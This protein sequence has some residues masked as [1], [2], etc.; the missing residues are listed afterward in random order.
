[1]S[2]AGVV[3]RDNE[4]FEGTRRWHRD[5]YAAGV[6]FAR[7]PGPIALVLGA[8][9]SLSSNCPNTAV[10]DHALGELILRWPGRTV[11]EVLYRVNQAEIQAR[12]NPLFDDTSPYIGYLS[13]AALGRRRRVHVLN[14]NWDPMIERACRLLGIP[15]LSF[16]LKRPPSEDEISR[17]LPI[18]S[19]VLVAHVH[20]KLGEECRYDYLTTLKL[21]AIEKAFVRRYFS[22][23]PRV[24]VGVSLLGDSDLV[25]L[26]WNEEAPA[27]TWF[28]ARG[29][30][31][32]VVADLRQV[33]PHRAEIVNGE[34]IDFDDLMV[35][36][37][38]KAAH[39]IWDD[40]RRGREAIFL[41]PFSQIAWPRRT[42]LRP[43]LTARICPLV[44]GTRAGKSTLAHLLAYLKTL[45]FADV[46]SDDCVRTFKGARQ[47]VAALS[48]L[49]AD[50]S[51]VLILEDAFGAARFDDNPTL[52]EEVER[53]ARAAPRITMILTSRLDRWQEAEP[54]AGPLVAGRT[55]QPRDKWYARERLIQFAQV[56]APS[57]RSLV[58]AIQAGRLRT[59]AQ[60]ADATKGIERT[61]DA[62][63]EEKLHVL[64]RSEEL[65]LVATLVRLARFRSE[66]VTGEFVAGQ[67]G[68][69][70]EDMPFAGAFI[71]D[72]PFE[73]GRCL[74]L[75]HDEDVESVDRY[76]NMR[77]VASV[78]ADV[79]TLLDVD[80]TD[81]V[82]RWATVQAAERGDV[83]TVTGASATVIVDVAPD[84]LRT[85]WGNERV[86][87]LLIGAP[88]DHWSLLDLA[89]E[90][91]RLWSRVGRTAHG[92][93][94]L[95]RMLDDRTARG[96]Y[97]IL[98]ACL[99]LP[100]TASDEIWSRLNARLWQLLDNPAAAEEVALA[101][102]ALLWRPPPPRRALDEWLRA[103]EQRITGSDRRYG[104]WR[105]VVAYHPSGAR[106]MLDHGTLITDTTIGLDEEQREF[107]AWLVAWH[108]I[109]QSRARALLNRQP[110][111][112]K[113]FLCR[114]TYQSRQG[115]GADDVER[116]VRSLARRPS[117]APW[118]F[119]VV[120]NIMSNPSAA[121]ITGEIIDVAR[122][123]LAAAPVAHPGVV[124][125]A[126]TYESSRVFER[127]LQ[128]YFADEMSREALLEALASGLLIDGTVVA[129]PRFVYAL[130]PEL[131]Y[132]TCGV[133]WPAL[134]A[135][136]ADT[137]R[138]PLM[139]TLMNEVRRHVP[140][141]LAAGYTPAKVRA[142]RQRLKRGDL[143]NCERGA[144]QRQP[145]A[146]DGD[147]FF[148]LFEFVVR[149]E[150]TPSENDGT[151]F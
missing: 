49:T 77:G 134:D 115:E 74:T 22:P 35:I 67:L 138:A 50:D 146:G 120:C 31:D 86:V 12:L 32:A 151:L 131:I 2:D 10:V 68:R 63:V 54:P 117:T 13:L 132:G 147:V 126:I 36:L 23:Y 97:A 5:A 139:P 8:G 66:P 109:H 145:A 58:E 92:Q 25:D 33:L 1:M 104:L 91:V 75:S 73:G 82:A 107:A 51:G 96:A 124:S 3:T 62:Q 37:L 24:F 113:D 95:E 19:G 129:P 149:V 94:L 76:L 81:A 78:G 144:Q 18:D 130:Q 61:P 87:E 114:S 122:A 101:V 72:F 112:D 90:L 141:L 34:D 103:A 64:E 119:H 140:S 84:L 70:L 27:P 125:A 93:R 59:P 46:L 42:I 20:G 55:W 121:P 45:W 79:G 89:Y 110:W 26:L 52:L 39:F 57:D 53:V 47:T 98:E 65:A 43:F 142:A 106:T 17:A 85:G 16:D 38:G 127:E 128:S 143:R 40:F 56:L 108:F 48:P 111:V 41:P 71:H 136:L 14:L 116:L 21:D 6:V 135:L 133:E 29:L 60:I 44:S 69:A 123:A 100:H 80:V 148:Q 137:A 118:A 105:F 30:G 102:D 28:F 150:V 4:E 88:F 99:Y 15:C 7:T 9:S 83:D 11:R